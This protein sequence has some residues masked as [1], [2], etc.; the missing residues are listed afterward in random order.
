[1]KKSTATAIH[2]AQVL[3]AIAAATA[4]YALLPR[5]SRRG[6]VVVITG[7]SRGLGLALAERFG[8]AGSKLVLAA[9]NLEQLARAR[10]L[11]LDRRAGADPDDVLLIPADLT[12]PAQ[13][14]S[15]VNHAIG[16]FG[17]IDVLINNAGVIEVGPVEDQPLAAYR[18]AMATHFFR[19]PPHHPRRLHPP[20]RQPHLQRRPRRPGRDHHHPSGLAHSAPLRPRPQHLAALANEYLLPH[21]LSQSEVQLGLA[22]NPHTARST[23]SRSLE[24]LHNQQPTAPYAPDPGQAACTF[25]DNEATPCPIPAHQPLL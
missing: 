14:A 6:Q 11:L 3:T 17:H 9:R 7:G 8:R 12:D 10:N 22:F 24:V 5:P 2:A 13:A 18:R 15:L 21:P 4:A 1:M 20:R 25:K 23:R 19:R 16:H